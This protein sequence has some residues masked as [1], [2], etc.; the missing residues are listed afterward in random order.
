MSLSCLRGQ[1]GH[2][3]KNFIGRFGEDLCHSN[4]RDVRNLMLPL[5]STFAL[6]ILKKQN[7]SLHQTK[8]P[9]YVAVLQ[10][11]GSTQL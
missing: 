1:E 3:G 2:L 9:I 6:S 7:F 11:S 8:A 5:T 4:A 10:Q